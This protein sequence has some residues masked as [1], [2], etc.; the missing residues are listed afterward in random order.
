MNN[1]KLRQLDKLSTGYGFFDSF[2]GG[3]LRRG[4]ITTVY[5]PPAVGKT[6]FGMISAA[7]YIKT[8]GR[9]VVFVDSE[10]GFSLERLS[11]LSEEPDDILKKILFFEPVDFDQQH[12]VVKRLYMMDNIDFVIIDSIGSLYRLE[13]EQRSSSEK[14][15]K[16]AQ[17]LAL[18]TTLAR[19]KN[20]AVLLTNQEYMFNNVPEPLGGDAVKYWS[21][22]MFR[23]EKTDLY[24][25]RTATMLKHYAM[26]EGTKIQFEIVD[27]GFRQYPSVQQ[28]Q[29][30]VSGNTRQYPLE[31]QK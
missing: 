14:N 9:N 8:T 5:G 27:T 2:L 12:E 16:L 31:Q 28:G 22:V 3:G 30:P 26:P 10:G 21:K 29:V 25:I 23:F 13:I 7:N 6:N 11:Q 18:L 24:N 19:E 17:Q 1:L 4:N 20:C 15:K